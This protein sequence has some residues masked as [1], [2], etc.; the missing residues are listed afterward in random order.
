MD[1]GPMLGNGAGCM[2]ELAD[3]DAKKK[4]EGFKYQAFA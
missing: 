1:T 3:W 2:A 4:S